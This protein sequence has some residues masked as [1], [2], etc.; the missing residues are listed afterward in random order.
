[1]KAFVYRRYGPPERLRLAEI[2]APIPGENEVLIRVRAAAVNPADWRL[3]RGVPYLLRF[4]TG[5]LGPKRAVLGADI[6]GEIEAVGG[7]VESFR[8]GDEVFG[9]LSASGFGGFAEYVAAPAEILAP[10]PENLSFEQA[11][12]VPLAGVTALQGLRGGGGVGVGQRVLINGASGGVGTFA[13]QIASS[14]GAEVTGVCSGPNAELV[15][16]LGAHAVIDYTKQDF[17]ASGEHY[18]LI[19]DAVGNRSAA[20]LA[21]ALAPGGVCVIVGFTSISR[22]LRQLIGGRRAT[23]SG[24]RI[25]LLGSV[26][27]NRADLQELADLLER[28]EVAP[29]ID[30]TYPL[31]RVPEAVAYLERGRARGKV[32]ITV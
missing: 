18:H 16:S 9:D 15:R 23:G 29:V 22:L 26:E 17:A 24:K 20:D 13:V 30:R 32:V 2:D 31:E 19:V 6:A 10:K 28:G 8:P 4:Q 14:F 5:L 1:M 21:R 27:P 7:G 11:A 25:E 3:L 12:A